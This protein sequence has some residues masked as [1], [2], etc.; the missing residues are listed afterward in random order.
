MRDD[1]RR[2]LSA[3]RRTAGRESPPRCGYRQRTTHRPGPGSSVDDQRAGNRGALLLPARQRDAALADQRVVAL[4]KLREVLVEPRDALRPSRD[5]I[6]LAPDRR[7][8]PKAM[9][10]AIV[11]LNRN[12]SWA[13]KPIAPRSTASGM[14]RTS[15]PSMKTVPGGG[16][17][18]RG[19]RLRS[20]DLPEPV[21]PTIAVV[22]PR[23]TRE[24]NVRE[25]RRRRRM[26]NV[27]LRNS[28]A[29]SNRFG[30]PRSPTCRR[31]SPARRPGPRAGAS[32]TPSALQQIA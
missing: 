6:P 27:R 25:A 5:A 21:A 18:R 15:T 17:C 26:Q 3:S 2:A 13:T 30:S 9:F 10:S 11:A 23:G 19:S 28:I 24:R 20:V 32:T 31:R 7:A 1:D 8:Q 12:G 14:C 29:P 22:V 16:S 4:R